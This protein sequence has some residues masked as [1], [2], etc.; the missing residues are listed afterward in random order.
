LPLLLT[1]KPQPVNI[2][3]VAPRESMDDME[4]VTETPTGPPDSS[5]AQA[6]GGEVLHVERVVRPSSQAPQ[7]EAEPSLSQGVPMET[8]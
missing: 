3:P 8:S 1:C 7:P 2:A 5:T 6:T 4:V